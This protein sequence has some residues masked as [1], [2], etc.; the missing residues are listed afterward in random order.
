VSLSHNLHLPL[1]TYNIVASV[2]W[3]LLGNA[4]FLPSCQPQCHHSQPLGL[5]Q[6]PEVWEH[7]V[8]RPSRAPTTQ[9]C[10]FIYIVLSPGGLCVPGNSNWVIFSE[11][12]AQKAA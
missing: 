10:C 12:L 2:Q 11:S 4:A 6:H 8:H 5:G 1:A 7:Q 9:Q 3:A